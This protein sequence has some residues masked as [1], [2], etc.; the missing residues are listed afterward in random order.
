MKHFNSRFDDLLN[1]LIQANRD[2][3]YNFEE[4]QDVI[5]EFK[6]FPNYEIG[7][8]DRS[9]DNFSIYMSFSPEETDN[10]E[11]YLE[12]F[13]NHSHRFIP[14]LRSMLKNIFA[15]Y[16]NDDACSYLIRIDTD[17]LNTTGDEINYTIGIT[18]EDFLS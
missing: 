9:R 17:H 13:M 2:L 11:D 3:N 5:M 10:K 4:D 6:G 15:E 8:D 1:Q 14:H 18:V 12:A 16:T 7:F